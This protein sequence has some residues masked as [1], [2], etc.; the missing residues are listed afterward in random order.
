MLIFTTQLVSLPLVAAY[1]GL[2]PF[3]RISIFQWRPTKGTD[4][5]P[6]YR[7]NWGWSLLA[8]DSLVQ[9]GRCASP[10][11][12]QTQNGRL[13]KMSVTVTVTAGTS[14]LY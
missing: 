14:W 12:T 5:V 13:V 4:Y 6:R 7:R 1:A 2:L 8:P 9:L 10:R 11:I 3:R